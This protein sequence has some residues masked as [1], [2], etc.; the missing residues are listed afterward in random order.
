[1]A[2]PALAGVE[3][4]HGIVIQASNRRLGSCGYWEQW[5]SPAAAPASL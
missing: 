2:A 1:M 5:V 3:A 4:G